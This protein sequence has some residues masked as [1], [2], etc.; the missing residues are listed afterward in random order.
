MCWL[1]TEY[2][3]GFLL[4]KYNTHFSCPPLKMFRGGQKFFRASREI[5]PPSPPLTKCLVARLQ[6]IILQLAFHLYIDWNIYRLTELNSLEHRDYKYTYSFLL[7]KERRGNFYWHLKVEQAQFTT[8]P[9]SQR[10]PS[11][12]DQNLP[13]FK[14]L[15]ISNCGFSKKWRN[16]IH[17]IQKFLISKTT[18]ASTIFIR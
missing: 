9:N 14:K 8:L 18:M 17:N 15:I 16:V 13:D 1:K 5:F 10:Y 3:V 12:T 4:F 7:S 11:Q 6:S 2:P